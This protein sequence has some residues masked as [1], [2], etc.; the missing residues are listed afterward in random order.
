MPLEFEK[1][2]LELETRIAELQ[3]YADEKNVDMAEEIAMLQRKLERMR[4]ESFD[5]L[6]R[7]Q[8][9]QLAR[10]PGRPTSLDYVQNIFTD[11]EEL[12]GD[13][14][15]GDDAAIVTGL[16]KLETQSVVICAQQKGR[17]TKE[18]ISRNFGMAHPEG[19]RKCMRMMDMA[20]KF[21]LPIITFIDTPGAYPGVAA[22]ERG[23]AWL[24]AQSIQRMSRL[25]VP[26]IAVIV[27]EGGSGG[28]LALGV[29]NRVLI[30]ENAVYSVIS[31]ESCAAILWRD[32]KEA[33]K[34]A[35]AL[36]LCARDLEPFGIVDEVVIEPGGGAHNDAE[37][38]ATN[39]KQVLEKHMH[40]LLKLGN[41]A[42][43]ADRAARFRKLGV[44]AAV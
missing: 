7:W 18:N 38:A 36:K 16:A 39:L 11:F 22:E 5:G 2:S 8:R 10:A 12:H 13:R 19:F 33:E 31:P 44:F 3:T 20:D 24:I 32:A 30:M 42:L 1:P 23:Q 9:V 14:A 29:G 4:A 17:D 6:T 26:A 25:K 34:A 40:E 28:A 27:G 35:E 15:Y 43:M 21:N 41:S 37:G